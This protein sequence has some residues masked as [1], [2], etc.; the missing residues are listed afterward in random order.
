[1]GQK[2]RVKQPV[3]AQK[4]IGTGEL[5]QQQVAEAGNTLDL[6]KT[7]ERPKA[8]RTRPRFAD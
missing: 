2:S 4:E 7:I 3:R 1:M 5:S 6:D 8:S